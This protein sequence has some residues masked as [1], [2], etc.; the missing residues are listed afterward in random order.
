MEN[1][2]N[3]HLIFREFHGKY[4]LLKECSQTIKNKI[5]LHILEVPVHK[6]GNCQ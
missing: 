4:T 1:D 2:E 3:E 6:L 5:I